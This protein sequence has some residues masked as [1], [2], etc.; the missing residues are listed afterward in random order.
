MRKQKELKPLINANAREVCDHKWDYWTVEKKAIFKQIR[1][2]KI[3]SKIE[4]NYIYDGW[5]SYEEYKN[6]ADR[7]GK[8]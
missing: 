1:E 2:C 5:M 6:K 8:I 3:C 7:L 4:Y